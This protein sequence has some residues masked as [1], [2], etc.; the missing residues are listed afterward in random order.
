MEQLVKIMDLLKFRDRSD[1]V[2]STIPSIESQE[3]F[4]S[5]E[6]AL[7]SKNTKSE[8]VSTI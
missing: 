2:E 1:N 4:E 8:L 6:S 3:D 7:E 5:V